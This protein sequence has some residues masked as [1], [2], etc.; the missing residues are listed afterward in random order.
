[1]QRAERGRNN[2]AVDCAVDLANELGLPLLVYFSAISNFPNANLRHYVFLNQGLRDIE[3]DLA[4]RNIS[5]IVRRPPENSLEKLLE[6]VD[7]ALLIGDENPCREPERWRQ[8]IARRVKI[9]FWTVDAD[10]IVPS[11]LFEKAQYAAYVLR[12]RL[13]KLLPGFF[14]AHTNPCAQHAWRRPKS[15][16]SYPVTDDITAGW[17]N[18]DR[19]VEPVESFTGGAHAA[20]AR[21]KHFVREL[22]PHYDTPRSSCARE[23]SGSR[24]SPACSASDC[25]AQGSAQSMES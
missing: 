4:E 3:A 11:K 21:L 23:Y 12:P 10:V 19:S 7:A 8:V 9:P 13:Y 24:L 1:M 16:A 17:K 18:F 2:A 22:L 5:F 25:A 15:F 14:V 6:E 20:H